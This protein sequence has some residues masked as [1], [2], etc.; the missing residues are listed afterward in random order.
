MNESGNCDEQVLGSAKYALGEVAPSEEQHG[1]R[2]ASACGSRRR[3]SYRVRRGC[4]SVACIT[5]KTLLSSSIECTCS[6][7]GNSIY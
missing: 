5:I 1:L 6:F 2:R 3:K 7:S 4:S